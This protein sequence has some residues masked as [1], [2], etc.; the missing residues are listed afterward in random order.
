MP[1]VDCLWWELQSCTWISV[2]HTQSLFA[3]LRQASLLALIFHLTNLWRSIGKVWAGISCKDMN[4]RKCFHV[5]I[6][7][8]I[9]RHPRFP[10]PGGLSSLTFCSLGGLIQ[11]TYTCRENLNLNRI[12]HSSPRQRKRYSCTSML[13]IQFQPVSPFIIFATLKQILSIS[14]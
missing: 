1:E 4:G 11:S 3:F 12:E 6:S 8:S 7:W 10:A 14:T 2:K 9:C 5:W 13:Y